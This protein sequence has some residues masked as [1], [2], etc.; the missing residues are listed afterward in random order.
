M[1]MYREASI[2]TAI[3]KCLEPL[4]ASLW[5]RIFKRAIGTC[6]SASL[7]CGM[8]M[9]IEEFIYTAIVTSLVPVLAELLA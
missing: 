2:Y 6:C 5:A 8:Y 1:D 4:L 3:V 9:Y 7:G